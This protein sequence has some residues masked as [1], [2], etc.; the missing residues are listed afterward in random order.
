[1]STTIGGV[2]IVD[3]P[4]LGAA[5]DDSSVG[6]ASMPVPGGSP[7]PRSAPMLQMPAPEMSA[8]ISSITG[9]L[10]YSSVTEGHGPRVAIRRTGGPWVQMQTSDR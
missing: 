3:M 6:V 4:D 8:A 9:Y 5:T 2:R 10:T 1:M 7:P